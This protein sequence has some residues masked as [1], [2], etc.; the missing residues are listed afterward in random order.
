[1]DFALALLAEL[2]SAGTYWVFGGLVLTAAMVRL[3][4]REDR[5]RLRAVS[6][7]FL[8]HLALLPFSAWM[9]M[10]G[11]EEALVVHLLAVLAASL[12]GIGIGMT[13][14]FKVILP[15]A[16][17]RAP[18]IL[19][20]VVGA[21]MLL[22][23]VFAL[24]SRLGV[25]LASIIATSAVVTAVIGLSLQDTLGNVIGGLMLQSDRSIEVGD[26]IKF[27]DIVG[28]VIDVR[29]RYTAVE[30]RNWETVIIP[31]GQISK[32]QVLV[33]GRRHGQPAYWRRLIEF[34]V[35][36]RFAPNRVI[37]AA[38]QA[39][40]EARIPNVAAEPSPNCVVMGF[41]QSTARYVLRYHLTDLAV[42]DPTDSEVRVRIYFGLSRAGIT[43]ALPAQTVFLTQNEGR[44][45][46]ERRESEDE[47][48]CAIDGIGLFKML[49]K[50]ERHSLADGLCHAPFARGEVMTRQGAEAHWLYLIV[51]G[52]VSV[53]VAIEGGLER[54]VNTLG[55]GDFFGELSL[56][57]GEPRTATVVALTDV[58]CYRL[59]RQVFQEVIKRRPALAED[60]A[61]IL[62]ERR[63]GLM[64]VREN[65]DHEARSKRQEQTRLDLVHRIR[66]FFGLDAT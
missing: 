59:D 26:W 34:H 1:M 30:T 40:R 19:R 7:F 35:D 57:T 43:L 20:D 22:V 5:R 14:V 44:R 2:K 10:T 25:H 42:D 9:A 41:E 55:D 24:A 12:A 3:M 13:L 31:N 61:A 33:L 6:L 63:M 28:R 49:P 60:V 37:E 11:H 36:F 58:D 15:R 16:G 65:L 32:N 4:V 8:V 39:V 64:A 56:M 66:D 21:V 38:Q 18:R 53:Q 46:A 23:V 48:R 47:R 45:A 50:D 17:Y 54:E 62:A 29:W 27:N 51:R 52:R